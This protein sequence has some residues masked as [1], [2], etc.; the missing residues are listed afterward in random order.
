MQVNYWWVLATL[1]ETLMPTPEDYHGAETNTLNSGYYSISV[2][3]DFTCNFRP[4]SGDDY[5][6]CDCSLRRC[7]AWRQGNSQKCGDGAN[8]KHASHQQRRLHDCSITGW[9]LFRHCGKNWISFLGRQPGYS[10]G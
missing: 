4:G 2:C 5:G 3:S 8:S 1:F 7:G 6:S 9:D 10:C